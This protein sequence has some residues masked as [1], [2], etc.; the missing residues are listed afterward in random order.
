MRIFSRADLIGEW[1]REIFRIS[2]FDNGKCRVYFSLTNNQY[3]GIFK[4]FENFLVLKFVKREVN[5]DWVLRID[6]KKHNQLYITDIS[7]NIGQRELLKKTYFDIDF[8]KKFDFEKLGFVN[9]HYIKERF[10]VSS[11]PLNT[12]KDRNGLPTDFFRY[13]NNDDRYSIIIKKN[14]AEKIKINEN[15]QLE[16][17]KS[18]KKGELGFY[19]SFIITE[20]SQSEDDEIYDLREIYNDYYNTNNWLSDAAGTNDPEVMNDVEWNLD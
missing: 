8:L 5:V 18:I 15:L 13:W 19:T 4:I 11:L 12:A 10:K 7:M 9:I 6:S 20:Y 2:I 16:V 17:E 3:D 1:S 14:L